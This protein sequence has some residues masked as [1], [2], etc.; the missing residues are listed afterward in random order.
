[1]S[2]SGDGRFAPHAQINVVSRVANPE[3]GQT[4]KWVMNTI[5][6][7]HSRDNYNRILQIRQNSLSCIISGFVQVPGALP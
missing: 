6:L 3:A 2:L 5:I 7:M 4:L 1:M